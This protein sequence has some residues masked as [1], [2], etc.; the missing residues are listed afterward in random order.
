[1]VRRTASAD[2]GAHLDV[3]SRDGSNSWQCVVEQTSKPSDSCRPRCARAY[4]RPMTACTSSMCSTTSGSPVGGANSERTAACTY[5]SN[6][7]FRIV[8]RFPSRMPT[9]IVG[10]AAG[11]DDGSVAR[12][13]GAEQLMS[14]A[15]AAMRTAKR[16][17]DL[18][19]YA[20]SAQP[21]YKLSAPQ[22][23]PWRPQS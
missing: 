14:H 9:R 20:L 15:G 8:I 11:L 2:C 22:P 7:T 18:F 12:V 16:H 10:G 5:V 13:A 4:V 21:R 1:M 17:A 19:M 23:Q 3:V 6:G